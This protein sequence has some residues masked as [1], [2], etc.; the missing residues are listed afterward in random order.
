MPVTWTS[1]ESSS[2]AG[3]ATSPG[4][5]HAGF[6]TRHHRSTTLSPTCSGT[7][8][9]S[10][11]V[12]ALHGRSERVC[13]RS[14]RPPASSPARPSSLTAPCF[15]ACGTRSGTRTRGTCTVRDDDHLCA[16]LR[17]RAC[18]GHWISVRRRLSAPARAAARPGPHVRDVLAR[19]P[20][21]DRRA[22]LLA[23]TLHACA[24]PVCRH[25]L[26]SELLLPG[27]AAEQAGHQ[28]QD[29]GRP[30]PQIAA[31]LVAVVT[32]SPFEQC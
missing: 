7:E 14:K 10:S 28:L 30:T 2:T 22:R 23:S 31:E 25:Q 26:R 4:T 27:L 24:S 13:V 15:D 16:G 21:S 17:W 8:A 20:T 3:Q 5:V 6:W 29:S 9:R 19:R 18:E 12:S 1:F 32:G 11:P